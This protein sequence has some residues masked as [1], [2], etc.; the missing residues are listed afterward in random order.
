VSVVVLDRDAQSSDSVVAQAAELH[1][2]GLRVRT[3]SMFYEQWLGKLPV[4]E[5]ERSSLLF[6]ISEV[7]RLHYARVKRLIDLGAAAVGVLVLAPVCLAVMVGNRVGNRGPLFYAQLRVGKD[8]KP[9]SILK[10]RTMREARAGDGT[11]WT[12]QEDPRVTPFGAILRRIHVDELPQ[13]VN[14]FRGHL[15]FVGPRP[16]QPHYV[17]ALAEKLPF[18]E[19]RHIV[20]PGLTGWAQVKFGY[21]G[22]ETDAL[23]KLQ[24]DFYYLRHQSLGL[25]FRILGRTV[26]HVMGGGGR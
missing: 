12:Q 23:E 20:R 19:L 1:G 15:S 5:L 16:E 26:R 25:D 6:D 4:G 3:L 13:M 11:G 7:H 22:D 10:F 14:I 2:R 18:Y 8:G 21:A 24:F 17:D 9:F